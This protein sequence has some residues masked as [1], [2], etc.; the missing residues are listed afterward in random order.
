MNE[1][2]LD[3]VMILIPS[4][5][6]D[7][8]M[9]L[10]VKK[11]IREGFKNIV[12]VDDGSKQDTQK[13]FDE[14][15]ELKEVVLLRHAVNQGKGRAL[16]TGMHY[17]LNTYPKG[18]MAGIVTADA[19]GQHGVMDTVKVAKCLVETNGFIL[20]TRNFDESNVPF[21]SR[22]G[23]KITTCVFALFYGKKIRDT[24]TGLRGIPYE[25]VSE[26]LKMQGERFE[27]EIVMLIEAVRQKLVIIEEDI[28]TIYI[29]SNRATHFHAIK[30]SARIYKII[31]ET[32]FAFA[33]SGILSF[34]IDIGLFALLTKVVFSFLDIT[35]SVFLGTLLA[36]VVS[37]LFNYTMN[38]N[39]VFKGGTKNSIFK[40]YVLCVCQLLCSWG[41]VVLVFNQIH[42]D[43]TIIKCVVD[44]VLFF[45][46]YQIQRLWV[47]KKMSQQ[48]NV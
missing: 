9:V 25:F 46:S 33:I 5:D 16:K 12:I 34:V 6:P 40:Y 47:F 27:Y 23:N 20:G 41:L 39:T 3:K 43:T 48:K 7:E 36:R 8:Q 44:V 35:M 10:Y 24:Q 30:D 38:R 1:K 26:C 2:L 15:R 11:L 29:D 14:V 17:F 4:Y 19:D 31:L 21:K 32:F 42:F 37:S 18:E 22:S 45:I 28:E 13:Y